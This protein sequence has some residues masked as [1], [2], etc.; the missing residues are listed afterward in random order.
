MKKILLT[1]LSLIISFPVFAFEDCII[2]TDGKLTDIKIQHNDVI[3]VFPL[4]T[5][6][7]DKNTLIVHPLKTGNTKFSVIKNNKDRFIFNVQVCDDTTIIDKT[8]GFDIMIVDCPPSA[9]EYS[10]ELDEP[11][12]EDF[13][14]DKDEKNNQEKGYQKFIDNIDIPPI[15]RGE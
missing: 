11:P 9:Y 5:I 15:L 6:T 8:E 12:I 4:I 3:D 7:N 14:S 1:A 13:L 10:F 2:S